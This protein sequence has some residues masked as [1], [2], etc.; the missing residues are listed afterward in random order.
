MCHFDMG[1]THCYKTTVFFTFIKSSHAFA[2][3]VKI[4]ER[5]EHKILSLTHKVLT[6]FQTSQSTYLKDLGP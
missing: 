1:L 4:N 3:L 6:T 5:V 2:A